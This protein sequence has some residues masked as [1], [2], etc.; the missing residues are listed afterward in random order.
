MEAH[1]CAAGA[2]GV[3]QLVVAGSGGAALG[4]ALLAQRQALARLH[5]VPLANHHLRMRKQLSR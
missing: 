5:A 4:R 3:L 1:L 2:A